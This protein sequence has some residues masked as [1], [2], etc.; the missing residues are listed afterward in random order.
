SVG[1]HL[2]PFRTEKLSPIA[3]MVLRHSVGEYVAAFF[4]KACL[5]RQAFVFI[6]AAQFGLASGRRLFFR[7]PSLKNEGF[8]VIYYVPFA[9]LGWCGVS[10][11]SI[12]SPIRK[13]VSPP[14]FRN[15]SLKNEGFFVI[16]YVPF[17][18]L[19]W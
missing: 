17:A 6:G 10:L 5:F 9:T 2:F 12:A 14:F 13:L 3:Q 4:S 18:T 11:R 19:G 16:Y 7:N 15:P 8:F 1:A